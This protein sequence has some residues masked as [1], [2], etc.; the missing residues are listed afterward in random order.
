[1]V[2]QSMA[3]QGVN[4]ASG[5]VSQAAAFAGQPAMPGAA[6][7]GSTMQNL[8][9]PAQANDASGLGLGMGLNRSKRYGFRQAAAQGNLNQFVGGLDPRQQA[10]WNRMSAANGGGRMANNA[11]SF[12]TINQNAMAM[13]QQG[14]PAGAVGRVAPQY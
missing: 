11:R 2:N 9:R 1:M 12:G 3:A 6:P 14:V 7:V 8:S 13:R 4:P 5:D 10:R